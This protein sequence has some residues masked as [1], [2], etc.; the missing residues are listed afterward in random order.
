[1]TARL[2][3]EADANLEAK[4]YHFASEY[5]M[6]QSSIFQINIKIFLQCSGA[7]PFTI[8]ST[9]RVATNFCPKNLFFTVV[10]SKQTMHIKKVYCT[11]LTMYLPLKKTELLGIQRQNKS[12][13]T[14]DI[15]PFSIQNESNL[16]EI[17]H[18]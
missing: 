18:G 3:S 9:L 10:P 11:S 17:N 13:S 4:I 5:Y 15:C 16:K 8:S 12:F 7:E 1:M 14:I 2:S 6:T